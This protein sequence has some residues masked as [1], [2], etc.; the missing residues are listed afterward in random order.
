L[1]EFSMEDTKSFLAA[2]QTARD[3]LRRTGWNPRPHGETPW[4]GGKGVVLIGDPYQLGAVAQE[5][6]SS[7]DEAAAQICCQPWFR[8]FKPL[9][10]K[11][12]VRIQGDPKMRDDFLGMIDELG[13][14]T[15]TE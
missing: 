1:E 11:E 4:F 14:K 2:E 15:K 8:R 12:C 6:K 10:L 5:A 9:L 7:A 3:M 13:H